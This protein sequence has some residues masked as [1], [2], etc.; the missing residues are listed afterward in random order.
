VSG[1][2]IDFGSERFAFISLA[3][4]DLITIEVIKEF[5]LFIIIKKDK[6]APVL[7]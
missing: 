5:K 3:I 7:N 4:S 1:M 6:I 2:S